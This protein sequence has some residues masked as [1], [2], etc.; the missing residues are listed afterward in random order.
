MKVLI[1]GGTQFIGRHLVQSLL[2]AG[3]AVTTFTRGRTPDAHPAAV[4]RL[5][6]DRDAGVAG[7][8]PLAGR[9]W[10]ACVDLSGYTPR[11]VRASATRLRD[12]VGHYAF[13]SSVSAYL[14][15]VPGPVREDAPRW[16]PA[17]ADVTEITAETYGPL[18]VT[19][20]D[21]VQEVFGDRCALLRPQIVAGAY[22]PYDRFTYWVRR[23]GRPGPMLAPGAGSDHL[24]VVDVRDVA[25]FLRLVC[26]RSLSGPFNLAGPR[27]TWTDF[28]RRL[29]AND[30]VWVPAELI[31]AAGLTFRELPLFRSDGAERSGLMHVSA[32][33]AMAAGLTHTPPEETIAAVREWLPECT[34][35]PALSAETEAALMAQARRR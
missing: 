32:G 18:K 16:P 24:Q 35:E 25:R 12:S 17:G 23:A 10:D 31:D 22:D 29:G 28:L 14:D 30:L 6:G 13:V 9:T 33:R 15:T 1:L 4:E 27:Q 11:Q 5:H 19:C 7:L 21:I 34:L 8:A 20:E 3:H 26:E 2:G